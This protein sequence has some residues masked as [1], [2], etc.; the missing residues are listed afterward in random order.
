MKQ[1]TQKLKNG[2]MQIKDTTLPSL[3]RGQVLVKN[4]YSLISAGTEGST[5]KTARSGEN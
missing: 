2:K 5:V 4:Y 3:Q 1:L